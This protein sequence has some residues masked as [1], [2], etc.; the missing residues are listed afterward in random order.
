MKRYLIT[1]FIAFTLSTTTAHA[2]DTAFGGS[3]A[4]PM[5][6]KTGDVAMVD[7]HI[8]I[9]GGDITR[10]GQA[11][12]WHINCDFTFTNSSNKPV[13]LTMG[14]PFPVRDE[15]D[16]VSSPKGRD[17]KVGDPLVYDFKVWIRGKLVSTKKTK[18]APNPK[19]GFYYKDAYI[20]NMTFQPNETVKV[21]HTYTTGITHD[22]MGYSWASYVLKT[23]GMWKGGRIGRS[24]LEVMPNE[25][26]KLCNELE[27]ESAPYLEPKPKGI[28]TIGKRKNRKYTW[29]L[30]NFK[31]TEDMHI[32]MQTG[33]NFIRWTLIYKMLYMS[34]QPDKDLQK[35]SADELR[36]FRNTI[37]AQYGRMFK[38]QKL[39]AYFDKQWWYTRN[40]D[41]S[42]KVL[43]KD[44]KK[45]IARISKVESQK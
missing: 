39:Q 20:W 43:T 2:N 27:T 7:E 22:A 17:P 13:T 6:I 35:K 24:V 1:L 34:D 18:I 11:D 32:C 3:G 5:P 38:D 12:S 28:K 23:G 42:D 16:A 21:R 29:D 14:F 25:I 45:A 4:S 41:Y 40:P 33:I 8:V 36:R 37:F 26:T 30:K 15:M 19:E 31:P 44:D 10:E 9:A